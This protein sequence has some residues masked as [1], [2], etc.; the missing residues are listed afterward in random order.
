MERT[1][2]EVIAIVRTHLK[3]VSVG[4]ISVVLD[5]TYIRRK[6]FAWHVGVRPS[7]YPARMYYLYDELAAVSEEIAQKEG[8]NVFFVVGEPV[9]ADE[10]VLVVSAA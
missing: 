7:R 9:N 1:K 3:D 8:V 2:D 5:D 10:E 4:D 6:E